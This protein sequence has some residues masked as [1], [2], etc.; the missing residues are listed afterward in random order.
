MVQHLSS[1]CEAFIL[2]PSVTTRK[3]EAG[4]T[5]GVGRKE[6][7]KGREGRK[8]GEKQKK[9]REEKREKRRGGEGGTLVRF[10]FVV[11]K[12]GP[13]ATGGGKFYVVTGYR[14]LPH[15]QGESRQDLNEAEAAEDHYLPACSLQLDGLAFLYTSELPVQLCYCPGRG[16]DPPSPTVNQEKSPVH[17]PRSRSNGGD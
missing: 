6:G 11:I 9:G 16:L 4:W 2:R 8:E 14:P 10:S 3:R 15:P 7:R 12:C 17:M 1:V 13:K 5:E